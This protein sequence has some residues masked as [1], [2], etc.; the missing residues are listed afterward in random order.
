MFNINSFIQA[1]FEPDLV[2]LFLS[3]ALCSSYDNVNNSYSIFLLL[4]VFHVG[5]DSYGEEFWETSVSNKSV[6]EVLL[7]ELEIHYSLLELDD[8]M[9]AFL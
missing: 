7:S 8:L 9:K 6:L 4:C 5:A 3:F 2:I 1:L